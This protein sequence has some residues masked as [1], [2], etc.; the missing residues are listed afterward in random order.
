MMYDVALYGG[1]LCEVYSIFH[2]ENVADYNHMLSMHISEIEKKMWFKI[3]EYNIIKILTI[4]F[5]MIF[6]S[7]NI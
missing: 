2:Y 3:C 5:K 4:I 1:I 6:E 7:F